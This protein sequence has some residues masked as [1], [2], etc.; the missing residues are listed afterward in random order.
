MII[1]ID[2][3]LEQQNKTRYW[4]SKAIGYSYPSLMKLCNNETD[5]IRFDILEKLC[6]TLGC[7]P[8]DIL[9]FGKQ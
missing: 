4:L 7:T 1:L 3:I 6:D 2:D 9:G 5:S 8:N